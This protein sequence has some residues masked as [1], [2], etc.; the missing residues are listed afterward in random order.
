MSE[1]TPKPMN[2]FPLIAL[3]VVV[4]LILVAFNGGL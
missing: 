3:L 4:V 1:P 2:A